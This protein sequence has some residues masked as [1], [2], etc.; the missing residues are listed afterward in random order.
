[1]VPDTVADKY[2]RYTNRE[3]Y[4]KEKGNT[5]REESPPELSKLK[6]RVVSK[7]E[8]ITAQPEQEKKRKQKTYTNF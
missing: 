2:A 6:K 1:M 4:Q 5:D 7:D 3:M 8:T